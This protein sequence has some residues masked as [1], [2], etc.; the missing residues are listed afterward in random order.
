MLILA[1]ATDK[2]QL[3]TTAGGVNVHASYLDNNAGV[4]APGRQNTRIAAAGTNDVLA[5]PPGSIFRNLKTLHVYNGGVV[6]NTVTVQHTDG[7]TVVQLHQV[8]LAIGATLQ[9]VDEVG[10][11]VAPPAGALPVAGTYVESTVV[12]DG[13]SEL[14]LANN[15]VVDLMTINLNAGDWDVNLNT[16]YDLTGV[17]SVDPLTIVRS[18]ISLASAT[19]D[20]TVGRPAST[21]ISTIAPGNYETCNVPPVRF[22]LVAPTTIHATVVCFGFGG[23]V[24]ASGVLRARQC[25]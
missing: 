19:E 4:V 16:L 24:L 2:L 12:F 1:S 10:F 23:V 22:V 3:V 9:Y 6:A 5:P 13:G 17:V 7:T 15:V 18:T 11:L 14:S 8:I 21:S 20:F 25:K